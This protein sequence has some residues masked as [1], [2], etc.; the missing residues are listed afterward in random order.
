[1]PTFDPNRTAKN[2]FERGEVRFLTESNSSRR[3]Q[4]TPD[5]AVKA[6]PLQSRHRGLP[7]HRLR[8]ATPIA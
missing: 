1:M 3:N 4:S 5:L 7:F 2:K 6:T 8:P